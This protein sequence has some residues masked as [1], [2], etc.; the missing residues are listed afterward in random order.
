MK[1]KPRYPRILVTFSVCKWHWLWDR[2]NIIFG[3]GKKI[4]KIKKKKKKKGGGL[5][6]WQRLHQG[7]GGIIQTDCK[8]DKWI[9]RLRGG[10]GGT[11]LLL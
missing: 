3:C 1:I 8:N 9:Y 2:S 7:W 10:V 4:N 5:L 6:M 11:L